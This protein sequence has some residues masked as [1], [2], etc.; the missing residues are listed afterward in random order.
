VEDVTTAGKLVVIAPMTLVNGDE[1]SSFF[2]CLMQ[3]VVA[4]L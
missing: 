2:S 4:L 3:A 1:V